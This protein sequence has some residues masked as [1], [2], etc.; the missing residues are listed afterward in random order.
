MTL[1]QSPKIKQGSAQRGQ[2]DAFLHRLERAMP[3]NRVISLFNYFDTCAAI[4]HDSTQAVRLLNRVDALAEQIND[5]QLSRYARLV[6]NTRAKLDPNLTYG[7]KAELFLATGRRAEA[8]DDP[9]IAAVCLHFAGQY[10]FFNEEYGRAFEYLLAANGDFQNVGYNKVPGISRY[11]HELAARYYHFKEYDKAIA[12][13]TETARYPIYDNSTAFHTFN[14]LGMVYINRGR[15]TNRPGD[16]PLS[17]KAFLKAIRVASAH[18]DSLL[19]GIAAGNLG[20]QYTLQNRWPEALRSYKLAYELTRRFG[21]RRESPD[22]E[23]RRIANVFFQLGQLDSCRFYLALSEKFRRLNRRN[24]VRDGL[25]DEYNRMNYYDVARRYHQATGNL[26]QAYQYSDS[27]ITLRERINKR[28]NAD[29]MSLVNQKLLIQQHQA[30]VRAI[31]QQKATQ[32][33]Q[34]WFVALA[35]ALTA[36]L[37][38]R[39]Y[40][41]SRLKR[42]QEAVINAER[43]KSLRLEKQVVEHQLQ[44]AT[45]SLSQFMDNLREKNT[46]IDAISAELAQLSAAGDA[47]QSAEPLQ[48]T[49]QHLL[50]S[51]LLTHDDWHEFRQRF[52]R[53][54]PYF[55]AQLRE[56]FAGISPAEERLLALSKLRV[57]TRQMSRMLGISPDSIRKTRYRLRKK[58][59]QH[60]QSSLLELLSETPGVA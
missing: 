36:G 17:E 32:R 56:Q 8:D 55:F 11:L 19:I 12:L 52:D 37:F 60:G 20:T 1:A 15:E 49:Q 2:Q 58:L 21:N 34:F 26:A 51:S 4:I 35:L 13:L 59:T 25:D 7:Q 22:G 43:E 31:E 3:A 48:Q 53:V 28:Y 27:V 46:L 10:Y 24:N 47:V 6:R 41:L 14:T 39:L 54:H 16:G 40:Q 42:R 33:R 38:L 45:A 44:Q 5:T 30:E 18:K 29:R 57:D 50:N 23:V 9:E